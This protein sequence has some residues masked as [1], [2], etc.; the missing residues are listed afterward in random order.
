MS[1]CSDSQSTARPASAANVES[2]MITITRSPR[3]P[4]E[5][6]VDELRARGRTSLRHLQRGLEADPDR[7]H[8]PRRSPEQG[9]ERD[10]ADRRERGGDALDRLPDLILALR[11]HGQHAEQLVDD[12]LA[13]LVV[14]EDE[15]EDR[16]E[17]DRQRE[18]REEDAER[19]RRRVL[20]A[21]VAEHVLH[22]AGQCPDEAVA[23]GRAA[24][25]GSASSADRA[26][27][28]PARPSR[29]STEG[30]R[31][32][33]ASRRPVVGGE[34]ARERLAQRE[35]LVRRDGRLLALDPLR[36][37]RARRPRRRRAGGTWPRR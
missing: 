27:L 28:P 23:R 20:R 13:E 2:P 32:R 16:D 34:L 19:D 35:Q 36:R 5:D 25:G 30:V 6:E 14:L 7:R 3:D 26:R 17:Q 4:D 21:A 37:K 24:H 29:E 11:G 18:E 31:R 10:E 33:S 12:A 9:D 22:C 15:P 8:H 1:S